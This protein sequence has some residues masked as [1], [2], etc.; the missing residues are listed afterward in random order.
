MLAFRNGDFN[1][2]LPSDLTGLDGKIADAFNDI[3]SASDRRARET[4]RVSWT[5]GKEGKLKQRMVVPDARALPIL[6]P[7]RITPRKNIELALQ[8]VAEIRAQYPRATLIVSRS[9]AA[10][11]PSST[12]RRRSSG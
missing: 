8:V 4:A 5:V 9:S 1:V 6:L 7:V 10:C 11:S 12:P 3:V 2:R